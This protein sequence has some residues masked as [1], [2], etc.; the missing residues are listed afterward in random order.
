MI[1]QRN[2]TIGGLRAIRI[3]AVG[4]LLI[5]QPG[6]AGAQERDTHTAAVRPSSLGQIHAGFLFIDGQYIPPPYKISLTKKSIRINGNTFAEDDFDLSI[7]KPDRPA[8]GQRSAASSVRTVSAKPAKNRSPRSSALRAFHQ[9]LSDLRL[10]SVIVLERQA[11]PLIL[12]PTREG[13]DLLMALCSSSTASALSTDIPS[14]LLTES[15]RQSW[16]QLVD[17]FEVSDEFLQR[18]SPT[19]DRMEQVLSDNAAGIS[20]NFWRERISFPLTTFA[21]VIVVVAF[22]HLLSNA[23]RPGESESEQYSP[24]TA[25]RVIV[26]SLVLVALLSAIDLIWTMLAYQAG[27]MRELNPLGSGLIAD[28]TQLITFKVAVTSLAIA[29]LYFLHQSPLA[30][31]ASW[32]CCLILTLLTARW[33]T[34]QSMFM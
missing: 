10:G 5:P 6:F 32:W 4:A 12:A 1:E 21:M 18:A 27:S 29:L 33:L 23:P 24:A 19:I 20:A 34:F 7:F 15:A 31:R 25:K 26:Q 11:P 22:G 3:L 2:F 8:G 13:H 14:T 28:P 17:D 30:Q 16:R 9:E